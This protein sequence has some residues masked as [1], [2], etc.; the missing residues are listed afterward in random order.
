MTQDHNNPLTL[1]NLREFTGSTEWYRHSLTA[2]AVYTEG[3]RYL[4]ENGGAYWLIDAIVS[5]LFTPTMKR[6]IVKDDRLSDMQFWRL[7][8]SEDR[9]AVL[10]C[11]ADSDVKPAITQRI[12]YTDFPLSA[13]DIWCGFDGSRW[14]LY[15]PSEH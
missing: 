9:K 11:R 13:I 5:H 12:P 8:V 3:V 7:E 1:D 15:L 2:K 14:T 4:A 6:A 10:T